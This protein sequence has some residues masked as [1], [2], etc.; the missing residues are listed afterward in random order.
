MTDLSRS[1]WT[2]ARVRVGNPQQFFVTSSTPSFHTPA[3]DLA[4]DWPDSSS[5]RK[6]AR[7]DI[8]HNAEHEDVMFQEADTCHAP[9]SP[10]PVPSQYT[11]STRRTNFSAASSNEDIAARACTAQDTTGFTSLGIDY[12]TAWASR[13]HTLPRPGPRL[14]TTSHATK[15]RHSSPPRPLA[16]AERGRLSGLVLAAITGAAANMWNFCRSTLPFPGFRAGPGAIYDMTAWLS[17]ARRLHLPAEAATQANASPSGLRRTSSS[18]MLPGQYP[19][20]SSKFVEPAQAT[21]PQPR[22]GWVLVET[23]GGGGSGSRRTSSPAAR[24]RT[25]Y[26]RSSAASRT[27]PRRRSRMS[28]GQMGDAAAAE[29]RASLP[30]PAIAPATA[31]GTGRG[32]RASLA[33]SVGAQKVAREQR[34]NEASLRRLNGQL[35]EM[36]REGKAA[37]A[38][39]VEVVAGEGDDEGV[40]AEACESECEDEGESEGEGDDEGV[41]G[42]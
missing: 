19:S 1:P 40:G 26:P 28:L 35:Q 39:R 4:A 18:I 6:R 25:H 17:P 32:G 42:G 36:I 27:L 10:P 7:H 11:P 8:H 31:T 2:P 15:R 34:R 22:D 29:R 24:P 38:M 13:A 3:A 33:G 41:R 14:N 9:S 30:A 23:A 5:S 16:A 20:A 21:T 37:L 12:N